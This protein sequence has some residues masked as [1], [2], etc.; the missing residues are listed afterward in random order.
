MYVGTCL[1]EATNLN[2]GRG[3]DT[4]FHL[5]GAPWLDAGRVIATIPAGDRE[6]CTLEEV[7]YVPKSIPG[8]ASH[9]RH[10]GETCHG[11][12]VHVTE[13][14]RLRA[15]RLAVSLLVAIRGNHPREFKWN[16]ADF[17]D[18]LAGTSDLRLRIQR[19]EPADAIVRTL[20]SGLERFRTSAPRRY[21]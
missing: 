13:P 8:K 9:P 2:E 14:R 11:I 1:F 21:E 5:V 20:E 10:L 6:G 12:R 19:E 15:F 4:P 3:T 17:F 18:T 16:T 7:Q